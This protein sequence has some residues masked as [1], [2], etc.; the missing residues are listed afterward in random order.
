M[1]ERGCSGGAAIPAAGQQPIQHAYGGLVVAALPLPQ[2]G[3]HAL[4]DVLGAAG[5]HP[6]A[7][8]RAHPLVFIAIREG[9]AVR[10]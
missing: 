6:L 9:G 3:L 10:R 2:L 1:A 7:R 4:R 8:G 5:A